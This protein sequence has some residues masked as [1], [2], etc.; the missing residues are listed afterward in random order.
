MLRRCP[1][2]HRL[3]ISPLGWT[4]VQPRW[5]PFIPLETAA[6]ISRKRIRRPSS[7]AVTEDLLSLSTLA[8]KANEKKTKMVDSLL[9]HAQSY[10]LQTDCFGHA[11]LFAVTS[12]DTR[13]CMLNAELLPPPV[14]EVSTRELFPC[15]KNR[16]LMHW[17]ESSTRPNGLT[18]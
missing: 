5:L 10:S 3:R 9:F 13:V 15:V 4:Y 2:V 1:S 8:S 12:T 7:E 11:V 17:V 16:G 14:K 6:I 18:A